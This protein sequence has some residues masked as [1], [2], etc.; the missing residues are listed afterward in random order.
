Q[1]EIPAGIIRPQQ[2]LVF[3]LI[4]CVLFI[5]TTYFINEI[6]LYL[7]P[8]AIAVV[9]FY[10]YTKRVTALCHLVLGIGLALAP[11]GA[12]LAVTGVFHITPLLFSFIVFTW[13][14]GFDIIYALQDE[15]FDKTHQLHSIPAM[16]G[17]RKALNVSV[18]I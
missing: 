10:S 16:L 4:N 14:S 15:E 5:L 11:I 13:V 3:T 18:V 12:Y 6:C 8:I 9:L 17:K 2:A 1:R 7:S